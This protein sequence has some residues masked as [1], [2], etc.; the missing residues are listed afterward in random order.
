MHLCQIPSRQS[1]TLRFLI[2]WQLAKL[3]TRPLATILAVSLP[4][5]LL[6]CAC[7]IVTP[8]HPEFKAD[9]WHTLTHIF[10][11][12]I[13][14]GSFG[15]GFNHPMRHCS[16][17]RRNMLSALQFPHIIC[18]HLDTELALNK[19]V[20]LVNP[21]AFISPFGVI[22]KCHRENE[23][24]LIL[25]LSSLA[26]HSINDGIYIEVPCTTLQCT[27]LWPWSEP[28]SVVCY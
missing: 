14:S 22:P 21:D 10:A 11:D 8:L 28:L 25:D 12:Y 27:M 19:M 23:W 7:Q 16:S 24:W 9:H 17:S 5:S 18:K 3:K 20:T 6:T 26:D 15:I 13:I 2:P 1:S 4:T